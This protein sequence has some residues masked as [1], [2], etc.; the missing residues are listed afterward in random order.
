MWG[1][2]RLAGA[3]AW[4]VIVVVRWYH[5]TF[6]Q[7]PVDW[8][9]DTVLAA[10]EESVKAFVRE[11]FATLTRLINGAAAWTVSIFFKQGYYETMKSGQNRRPSWWASRAGSGTFNSVLERDGLLARTSPSPALGGLRRNSGRAVKQPATQA[12]RRW[13]RLWWPGRGSSSSSKSGERGGSS[14]WRGAIKRS[15]SELFE[16]PSGYGITEVVQRRGLLE[17]TR[18]G[19]ELAVTAVF[20][21]LRTAIRAALFLPRQQGAPL[22]EEGWV[23]R[24][25]QGGWGL[26]AG[27]TGSTRP[28]ATSRFEDLHVWT[29]SDVIL[30]A[31]YPLEEHIVTTSDGYV[32]QMQRI[33]R[34]GSRDVVFFMHG[35]LDTSLGWVANGVVGSQAF[36]AWDAGHDVWLGNSRSNPPRA[37]VD[38]R[39]QGARY[40]RY[41]LNELGMEDVAAQVDHIHKVKIGELTS[42]GVWR[43][44]ALEDDMAAAGHKAGLRRIASDSALLERYRLEVAAGV[45]ARTA[46]IPQLARGSLDGATPKEKQQRRLALK[47]SPPAED[48]FEDAQESGEIA[49]ARSAGSHRGRFSLFPFH[50]FRRG[51]RRQ[52]TSA[53]A[54]H[55]SSTAGQGPPSAAQA[56]KA[57]RG[58]SQSCAAPAEGEALGVGTPGQQQPQGADGELQRRIPSFG[59]L[60]RSSST[61]P[62]PWPRQA[63]GGSS[64]SNGA[65]VLARHSAQ[66]DSHYRPVLPAQQHNAQTPAT[67]AA[68]AAAAAGARVEELQS[69]S[70]EA[71]RPTEGVPQLELASR[72]SSFPLELH[73]DDDSSSSGEPAPWFD[74]RE[75]P[76]PS[77]ASSSRSTASSGSGSPVTPS[78]Y[79]DSQPGARPLGA[80]PLS[81]HSPL[82]QRS[83]S[84]GSGSHAAGCSSR[85]AANIAQRSASGSSAGIR[86]PTPPLLDRPPSRGQLAAAEG[87]LG[88]S[89]RWRPGVGGSFPR[90]AKLLTPDRVSVQGVEQSPGSM[91]AQSTPA[92][93]PAWPDAQRTP[94]PDTRQPLRLQR[95]S[96]GA[97]A[98]GAFAPRPGPQRSAQSV[99]Q[100]PSSAPQEPY[101]LRAV[102]HSLGAASLLVYAVMSKVQGRPH[103]LRRMVLLTPAGFHLRYPKVFVPFMWVVPHI[104][105]I[106]DWVRPGIGSPAYLPSSLLRYITFKLTMDLDR[107]PG[108]N[109]L[110]RAGI[111]ALLSGDKSQWDRALQMPHY[112][113]YSMPALSFHTGNHFLQLMRT[114]KFELYDYGS[115]AANRAQYGSPRPPELPSLYHL[116]ADL[117]V[118]LVAGAQD[119]IIAAD[120]VMRHYEAMRQGGLQ[121]RCPGWT[122]EMPWLGVVSGAH[123]A[124]LREAYQVMMTRGPFGV[125]AVTYKEFDVGHLDVTF[126]VREDIRH[127]VLSRLQLRNWL[128]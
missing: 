17:D 115:P 16:R 3:A 94:Q 61:A 24:R 119:G 50:P 102:G 111:S 82:A 100:R 107:I 68:A 71:L 31:G 99:A 117:P 30:Q 97:L 43:S 62:G 128:G 106:M 124:G 10:W 38:P 21:A 36:A 6:I 125:Q 64:I 28:S 101:R 120:D 95:A 41:S 8:W 29:A 51:R 44:A 7:P 88:G 58:S 42:G 110:T 52:Q 77:F 72:L 76:S 80:S 85:P 48:E 11:W 126:A 89:P 25:Q 5:S 96:V 1:L 23:A 39:M 59:G 32:L 92:A 109:E 47:L 104:V 87:P 56:L 79:R 13:L 113:T 53:Q 37:H 66:Q 98:T 73:S 27:L 34:K 15:G 78:S 70:L 60:Q 54:L 45:D 67:A 121:G 14:P 122:G 35:I 84:A 108:L 93:L 90:D 19:L 57:D 65:G 75:A 86:S 63:S 46:T 114:G 55:T 20:E 4:W 103:R 127:Y 69:E 22:T 74:A 12:P 81:S 105:R 83:A 26:A 18:L 33:P 91:E 9:L 2:E 49:T 123:R 116:M 118:D 40:W 112:N